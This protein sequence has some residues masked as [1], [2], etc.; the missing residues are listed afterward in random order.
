MCAMYM[1]MYVYV[2]VCMYVY[3]CVHVQ[4]VCVCM[5]TV[6][7]FAFGQVQV[8]GGWQPAMMVSLAQVLV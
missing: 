6:C 1:C 3:V 5:Y 8:L 4:Y 7:L 2:C